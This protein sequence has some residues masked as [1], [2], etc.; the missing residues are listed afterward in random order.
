VAVTA[1]RQPAKSMAALEA[2]VPCQ[3]LEI[4][5]I[6]VTDPGTPLLTNRKSVSIQLQQVGST[7]ELVVD[8]RSPEA[9]PVGK[10]PLEAGFRVNAEAEN[11]L[12]ADHDSGELPSSESWLEQRGHFVDRRD[13]DADSA[14][15]VG[16]DPYGGRRQVRLRAKESLGFRAPELGARLPNLECDEPPNNRL[17]GRRVMQTELASDPAPHAHV[18]GE[19]GTLGTN[20]DRADGIAI[21]GYQRRRIGYGCSL[22]L[23]RHQGDGENDR[24][25]Q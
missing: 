5:K 13:L 24:C 6:W 9:V 10:A 8:D 11:V 2:C 4:G 17:T 21:A 16:D 1:A 3:A 12:V 20:D 7:E 19:R 22:R 18:P 14:P 25:V 23:G 15:R